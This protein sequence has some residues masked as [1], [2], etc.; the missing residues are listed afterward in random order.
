MTGID[1]K[2]RRRRTRVGESREGLETA[3]D[4]K[5]ISQDE[6]G[7]VEDARFCACATQRNEMNARRN[8]NALHP[9][10]A[11]FPSAGGRKTGSKKGG[12]DA[13]RGTRRGARAVR[14]EEKR[15]GEQG[16]RRESESKE[17]G[18]LYHPIKR[19]V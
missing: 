7:R 10:R 12:G 19:G 17:R 16:E 14:R 9:P 18:A 11:R 8:V 1:R 13:K 4:K 2:R 6:G 5:G 15:G 3:A